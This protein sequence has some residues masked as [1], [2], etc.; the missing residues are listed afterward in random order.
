LIGDSKLV[1]P[2]GK[3]VVVDVFFADVADVVAGG[4]GS[5]Q[6]V[7]VVVVL[8]CKSSPKLAES[9]RTTLSPSPLFDSL[10]GVVDGIIKETST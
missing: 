4:V 5:G 3:W 1:P 10:P 9:G 7:D 6:P 8:K 2:N